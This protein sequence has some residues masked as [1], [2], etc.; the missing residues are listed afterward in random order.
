MSSD[1]R[2]AACPPSTQQTLHHRHGWIE[3]G[4]SLI[5]KTTLGVLGFDEEKEEDLVGY[6]ESRAIWWVEGVWEAEADS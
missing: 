5:P 3:T 2:I 1:I 6:Q 4:N